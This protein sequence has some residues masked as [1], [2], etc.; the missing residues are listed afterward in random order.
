[1]K[2]MRTCLESVMIDKD[3]K[4]WLIENGKYEGEKK[5]KI[6]SMLIN[7]KREYRKS[8]KA[9]YK[10]RY[11]YPNQYG[12]IVNGGGGFDSMWEKVFFKGER[13][14]DEDK[15]EF[16]EENWVECTPS[17]YDCTGQI[18]TWAID[19]FN[20]PSGVVAYLRYAMDV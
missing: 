11:L 8:L 6:D 7:D 2:D 12:E 16:I 10:K 19:V 17:Q 4:N 20:V 15:R 13:W 3:I 5:E 14:T 1:M 9:K 18:F